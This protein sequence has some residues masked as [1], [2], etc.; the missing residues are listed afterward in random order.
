MQI[1]V[2]C[3]A[4][5]TKPRAVPAE[6]LYRF[7]GDP[8]LY[9]NYAEFLILTGGR[10]RESIIFNEKDVDWVRREIKLLTSKRKKME[11]VY[12][13]LEIDQIGPKFISLLKRLKSNPKTGYYFCRPTGEPLE[14]KQVRQRLIAG[15]RKTGLNWLRVH[16]LR[17]TFAFLSR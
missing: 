9:R 10:A 14:Y 13:Y 7:A 5:K 16:D 12:R 3:G 1:Y 15:A 17:H 2:I 8:A 6:T 11:K 4:V